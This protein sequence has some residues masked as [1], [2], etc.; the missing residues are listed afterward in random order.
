MDDNTTV[1]VQMMSVKKRFSVYYDQEIS[2]SVLQLHYNESVSMMLALPEKG[3]TRLEEVIGQNHITKWH[4]W[5]KARYDR[6]QSGRITLIELMNVG[7]V[8]QPHITSI[9]SKIF[10][11]S[12][13]VF[14]EYQVHVP[15]MSITTT[16]SLKDVLS[17][18]GMLDIFSN[19]ADFSGISEDL[20]VAVSEVWNIFTLC[21]NACQSILP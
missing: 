4:R 16:Y 10:F 1:P 15:K 18:M 5:M 21:F 6:S 2:T 19:R 11:L 20:K 14:S 3:L 17:G 9:A 12:N 13:F 8:K 7:W